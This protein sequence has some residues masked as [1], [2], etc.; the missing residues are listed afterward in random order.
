MKLLHLLP[1]ILLASC[2]AQ[3]IGANAVSASSSTAKGGWE[4]SEGDAVASSEL[5][6]AGL[7]ALGEQEP[8]ANK[9][10]APVYAPAKE[11][12]FHFETDAI[13]DAELKEFYLEMDVSLEGKDIGTMTFEVWGDEAPITVRNF[14]RY[15]DEGFYNNKVFHRVL[16]DFMIQGGS[17]NN[18]GSGQ[19]PHPKIKAEFSREKN[20]RHR[21]GVLS[22]ARGGGQPDSASSQFFVI[23]D[24][25]SPSTKGLDGQYASFGIMI[26][27]IS[28][29]EQIADIPTTSNGREKSKPTQVAMVTECRVKRGEPSVEREE[30]ERPPLDLHGEPERV[31]I[32]HVLIS[33]A[34]TRTAATR[35]KEEAEKLANEVLARAKAGEDFGALVKEFTDDPSGKTTTPPGTYS[36]LNRGQYPPDEEVEKQMELQ[37]KIQ[38]LQDGL[39]A[40]VTAKEIT[41]DEAKEQFFAM[42]EVVE[43]QALQSKA[44]LNRGDMVAA[45]GNVG[46]G[47]EI[48]EIGM[49][50]YDPKDSPFGWHII[51]RYE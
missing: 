44:W 12:E 4:K 9:I 35:T 13:S 17:S 49:S 8:R 25:R 14:L 20:R 24:S 42:P 36:M 26:H 46:F 41:M 40:K 18:T 2:D 47:L 23:T 33:F 15:A 1:L 3:D 11:A 45:F 29:L 27:G 30:M 19:G 39:L 38:E 51:L 22:M 32:Q 31:R 10:Q 21:Y 7:P 37:T 5:T 6:E 50:Q 28:T 48:G 16:R 34:G 43:F